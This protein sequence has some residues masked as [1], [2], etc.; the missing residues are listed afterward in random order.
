M[1]REMSSVGRPTAV[2][3]ISIVTRPALGTLAA[4]ILARV[5]VKLNRE[6]LASLIQHH[7][8]NKG[9]T[10]FIC[11][12][13]ESLGFFLQIIPVSHLT[14][15]NCL[16]VCAKKVLSTRPSVKKEKGWE[17]FS[18]PKKGCEKISRFK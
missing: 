5:A 12:G 11:R 14:K 1:M 3:T 15:Q 6:K 9:A 13:P 16:S 4:P 17:K 7:C 10:H 18:R 8:I 2:K